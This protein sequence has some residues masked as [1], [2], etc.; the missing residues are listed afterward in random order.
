MLEA[1][2]W[3]CPGE[4][5]DRFEKGE[6]NYEVFREEKNIEILREAYVVH[7]PRHNFPANAII[8]TIAEEILACKYMEPEQ[9]N[10]YK[11]SFGGLKK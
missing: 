8:L 10:L 2:S 11:E 9:G 4:A 3:W 7:G 6:M 5:V 1:W